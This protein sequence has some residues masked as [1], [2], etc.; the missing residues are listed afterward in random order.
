MTSCSSA[1]SGSDSEPPTQPVPVWKSE[2]S[3]DDQLSETNTSYNTSNYS[4]L[5][6]DLIYGI[7]GEGRPAQPTEGW[8]ENY[9]D[10]RTSRQMEHIHQPD[11]WKDQTELESSMPDIATHTASSSQGSNDIATH[12]AS[13]S[14]GS[15]GEAFIVENNSVA[16]SGATATQHGKESRLYLL[17]MASMF[18]EEV[19]R[20]RQEMEDAAV[21]SSNCTTPVG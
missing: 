11:L 5:E 19:E 7:Q 14:Q 6:Q 15:N 17:G 8:I 2:P 13:S 10:S 4:L 3:T 1:D 12:T 20:Q 18:V 9:A 16:S 21:R